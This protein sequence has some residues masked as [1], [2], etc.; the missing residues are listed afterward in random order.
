MNLI[1]NE[2]SEKV[3][4]FGAARSGIAASRILAKQGKKV[5]LIDESISPKAANCLQE[6]VDLGV[7]CKFGKIDF[8]ILINACGFILSPGISMLHPFVQEAIRRKIKIESELELGANNIHSQI[9]AT[10]GTNGKSTVV[11]LISKI[12]SDANIPSIAAG[13]IG[14]AICEA[15]Q[16]P[17]SQ[18]ENSI[19]SIEVSSFQLEAIH[20]FHPHVALILNITPDHMDR[21]SSI[22]E[23]KSAKINITKNQTSVDYL[24][25]NLRDE[26][27]R[28]F[29]KQTKANVEWFS[30]SPI[31]DHG[32]YLDEDKIYLKS[33]E[34]IFLM[35]AN[36]I[37]LR[38]K[39]NIENVL[40]ASLAA[41]LVGVNP[42]SIRK[43]VMEFK[44]VEHRIEICG[45]ING[46]S[47]YND[48]KATNLDSLKVAL[49]A[50]DE[51]IILIAGGRGKE[52]TYSDLSSLIKKHVKLLIIL[53][54]EKKET[55][56]N[57]W[58][59]HV[60]YQTAANMEK[61]LEIAYEYAENNDI[62]LLSPGH[63]SFDLYKNYEER[64]RHFKE[65]VRRIIEK[66]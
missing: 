24:I 50:F 53:G 46:I 1:N 7:S 34:R 12:L 66:C 63:K 33:G 44:G 2:I 52:T 4:V 26:S 47:F 15:A 59:K 61:A 30:L 60:N 11:T 27:C 21:Y 25:L 35:N 6:L 57:E 3:V 36:E 8:E 32:A 43:S 55:L 14:Y 5:I 10:T 45:S 40:A 41:F 18:S 51:P 19:L 65:C 56:I 29:A 28:E 20:N 17:L 16:L 58:G 23:Y 9:I 49:E 13:N 64:G 54:D 31:S 42:E 39:H 37:P 62:I 48:S 38:G 22:E